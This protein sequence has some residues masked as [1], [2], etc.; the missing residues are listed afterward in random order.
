[1]ARLAA[2]SDVPRLGTRHAQQSLA[3][4]MRALTDPAETVGGFAKIERLVWEIIK[5]LD[6]GGGLCFVSAKED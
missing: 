6:E 5:A 3:P 2:K 1:M 4:L